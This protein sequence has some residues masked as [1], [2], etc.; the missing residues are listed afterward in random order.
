MGH[1]I[2]FKALAFFLSGA[3]YLSAAGEK[4]PL[5]N[6]ADDGY[7]GIWYGI[8][9]SKKD[10]KYGYNYKY[11]G[12][13]AVYPANHIPLAIYSPEANKTFFVF[14]GT[15]EKG[16]T[17]FHEIAYFDH[18]LKK[19]SRPTLLLDKGTVDAHDNPVI[20]MDSEGYIYVL[21]PTHGVHKTRRSF[22]SKSVRPYDISEFKKLDVVKQV[23]GKE[24]PMTNF[25]YPQVWKT[26][27]GWLM[28]FTSYDKKLRPKGMKTIRGLYCATSKDMEHW[29]EWKFYAGIGEGHYQNSAS[30]DGGKK[31][32]ACFNYHPLGRRSG[33]LNWRTNIYFMET[34]DGGKTWHNWKGEPIDLPLTEIKNNA[35]VRDYDSEK[36]NVYIVDM[37][38]DKDGQPMILY[39]TS[40]GY[41]SGPDNGP[42]KW[43][44]ARCDG[45]EWKYFDVTQSDNNYDFGS[46][47]L[48][49]GKI[50]ILAASGKG[51]QEYNT[52]GEMVM[53]ESLDGG[54]TWSEKQL[55]KSS[56]YNH[57]YPR[58]PLNAN[59]DFYGIW[60][61][62]NGREKSESSLYYCNSKGEVWKMPRKMSQ[63]FETGEKVPLK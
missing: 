39:I 15:N 26:P 25:S 14:G 37:A 41:E 30:F 40:R 2:L 10:N 34:S 43:V 45:K 27:D 28:L 9:L 48:E 12:G 6:S 3:I 54:K 50:R 29:S 5:K 8:P 46:L 31:I 60:A 62:G 11:S 52:G 44:L 61:D 16:S 19:L 59:P 53:L 22:I 47:Y 42:R 63:P 18:A 58:R 17:L 51:P 7:R 20:A 4:T 24:V 56:A 49:D 35:L 55:T 33:G 13:L 23:D 36:L 57:T 32:G 38:Y 21:S 1:S